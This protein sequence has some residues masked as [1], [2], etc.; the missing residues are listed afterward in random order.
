MDYDLMLMDRIAKIQAINKQYDLE[1]NSYIAYSGGFD[2]DVLSALVD[3][4]LPN[5]K[6]PRVYA[7][8]GIE[9][10][11]VREHVKEKAIYDDRIVIL[12]QT[13]NIKE[14]LNTYGYPFKS[15]E[16]SQRLDEFNKGICKNT[17]DGFI[18]GGLTANGKAKKTCTKKLL[19]QFEE[20][21]KYL[22]SKM[23]C[24]KLKKELMYNFSKSYNKHIVITGMRAEEGGSRRNI[25]CVSFKDGKITRFHPLLVV[26]NDF[27]KKF[28][29]HYNIK[30]CDLYYPPYNF[31]RTGCK[32]CPFNIELAKD[33]AIL[34][35]KLPN[36]YKQCLILWKP[37][38]KEYIRIGYR[39]KE[40]LYNE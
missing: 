28:I 16:Y 30:V 31:K 22:F 25:Q 1:N 23:C 17:T 14:T 10:K 7:N 38:Y 2:S 8:T 24:D 37:V 34:K 12:N 18:N 6:I 39:L 21:G 29:Q 5:N 36:E 32:G 15:K 35:E 33:L 19:Y 20:R 40:D 13:R 27:E 4:A 11:L 9:Y 3:V 26:D